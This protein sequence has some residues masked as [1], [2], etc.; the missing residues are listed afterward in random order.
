MDSIKYLAELATNLDNSGNI[1]CADVIDE[2]IKNKSVVKV[3]QYV[4]VI[5]YVLKQNRA[6]G[7]CIRKK[8]VANTGSM[9]QVVL[10]CLK[11][12]QDGQQYGNNDWTAKY[13]QVIEQF[14]ENFDSAHIAFIEAI[15]QENNLDEHFDRIKKAH[16][17]LEK[18]NIEDDL[19]SALVIDINL[20]KSSQKGDDRPFKVATSRSQQGFW[21]KRFDS[22]SG[23]TEL[24]KLAN[25]VNPGLTDLIDDYVEENTEK[26]CGLPTFPEN[27]SIL[28]Q[29]TKNK[30]EK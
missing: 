1:K 10:D 26:S 2:L 23:Q 22:R 20:L 7:N 9:Q 8:R 27:A 6:M 24:A 4:G 11:E 28:R 25:E 30:K 17:L 15:A 16:K 3:A 13:A 29:E 14:P 5:G 19:L 21:S 18:N 12:Y